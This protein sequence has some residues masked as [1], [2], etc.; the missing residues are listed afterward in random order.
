MIV[1]DGGG[2]VDHGVVSTL[3]VAILPLLLVY[4]VIGWISMRGL[5]TMTAGYK[6]LCVFCVPIWKYGSEMTY[7]LDSREWMIE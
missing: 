3:A 5:F 4:A 6:I 2:V 7:F 1:S